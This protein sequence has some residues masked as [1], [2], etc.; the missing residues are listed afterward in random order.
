MEDLGFEDFVIQ[1]LDDHAFLRMKTAN[2]ADA[3]T[4]KYGP[5]GNENLLNGQQQ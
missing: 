5:G 3:I 1:L 2:K 4:E